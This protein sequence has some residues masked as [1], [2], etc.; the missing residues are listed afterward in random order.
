MK[1]VT[2]PV[3]SARKSTEKNADGSVKRVSLGEVTYVQYDTVDEA[4]TSEGDP[5]VLK[6]V[7]A[8]LATNAKNIF[9]A[10]KVGGMSEKAILEAAYIWLMN[11][12]M[13]EVSAA[14]KDPARMA[15]LKAEAI[16]AVKKENGVVDDED[17]EGDN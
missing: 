12:K 7:N 17:G 11:N 13:A 10:E 4:R 3:T 6:L 9:R 14:Q 2:K 8:Q 16:A 15:A 5:T 1:T